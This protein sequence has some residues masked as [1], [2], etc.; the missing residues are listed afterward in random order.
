MKLQVRI[1][2]KIYD[3]Q[4]GNLSERPIL[5]TI[6]GETFEVWPENNSSSLTFTSKQLKTQNEIIQKVTQSGSA[7][8]TQEQA[9]TRG[10]SSAS[11]P[12][13]PQADLLKAIRAPIPG[14][15]TAIFVQQGSDVNV[16]QELC[17]L[18]AMKMNNSIRASRS[19]KIETILI[20]VG[21]H[22]KHNDVLIEFSG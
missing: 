9:Q 15:I 7:V 5:A 10:E 13:A 6:D 20:S 8:P 18:E 16:G 4:I 22:V 11:V 2:G 12:V 14:V 17:K 3:V 1:D 21:Q 19:G